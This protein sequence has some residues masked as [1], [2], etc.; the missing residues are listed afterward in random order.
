MALKD[1]YALI[2]PFDCHAGCTD[3]CRTIGVPSMTREEARRLREYLRAQGREPGVPKGGRCCY[4][5]ESGCTV[6]PVRPL[7]CRL[8]GASADYLCPKGARPVTLLHED[9]EAVIWQL[10]YEDLQGLVR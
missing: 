9:E 5:S 1:L 7:I 10:Y 6:Y 2:P 3:C 8:Y 4:V